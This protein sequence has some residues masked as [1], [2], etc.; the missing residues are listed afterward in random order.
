MIEVQNGN[1][2]MESNIAQT[3]DS[4]KSPNFFLVQESSNGTFAKGIDTQA[5]GMLGIRIVWV[6]M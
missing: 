2:E 6:N 3:N 5:F 4:I 1:S